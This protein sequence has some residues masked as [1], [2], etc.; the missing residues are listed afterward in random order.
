MNFSRYSLAKSY[1][2]NHQ[3]LQLS[4]IY[5][6]VF[7]YIFVWAGVYYSLNGL[8]KKQLNQPTK[9]AITLSEY[10]NPITSN[11]S[12]INQIAIKNPKCVTRAVRSDHF[13][14]RRDG[15][16]GQGAELSLAIGRAV[17][18]CA[19]ARPT[20]NG[21][22]WP[23]Q[24]TSVWD[25]YGFRQWWGSEWCILSWCVTF[26]YGVRDVIKWVDQI[27]LF[28]YTKLLLIVFPLSLKVEQCCHLFYILLYFFIILVQSC[29]VYLDSLNFTG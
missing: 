1:T 26:Q 15:G 13:I 4:F 24:K 21:W 27:R 3:L 25:F 6:V 22:R 12:S 23:K 9:T 8:K 5:L 18:Q 17:G 11:R 28:W 29:L 2:V 7:L 10:K 14:R 20:L 19:T 16:R